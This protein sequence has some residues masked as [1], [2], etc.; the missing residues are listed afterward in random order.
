[1]RTLVVLRVHTLTERSARRGLRRA[2]LNLDSQDLSLALVEN[3]K[4]NAFQAFADRQ[5]TALHKGIHETTGTG[6]LALG[7]RGHH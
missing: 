7:P 5:T 4:G 6:W 3:K 1:M 2:V